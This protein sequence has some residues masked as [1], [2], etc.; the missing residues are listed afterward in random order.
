[1]YLRGIFWILILLGILII[2]WY[3]FSGGNHEFI[4]PRPLFD[5]EIEVCTVDE[6][7]EEEKPRWKRQEECCRAIEKILGKKFRRNIRPDFLKNPETGANLELD[8]YN[9]ELK[10]AVEHNGIQHYQ[11][12][13]PFHKSPE[14]WEKQIRRDEFKI[15]VCDENKIYLITIPYTVPF[16]KIKEEIERQLVPLFE[17]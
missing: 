1:M 14:E 17:T 3:F 7:E 10:V 13:N 9:P 12:P 16:E 15:R 5:E 4:G 11:Y 2:F 8:C 6:E